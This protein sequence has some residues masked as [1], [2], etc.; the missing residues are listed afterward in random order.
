MIDAFQFL[1]IIAVGIAAMLN[2][3]DTLRA[4]ERFNGLCEHLRKHIDDIENTL[5]TEEAAK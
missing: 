4:I 3:K 5:P 2:Q 1:L